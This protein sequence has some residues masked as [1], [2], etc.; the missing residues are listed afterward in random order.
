MDGED[1][2]QR[3]R[4]LGGERLGRDPDLPGEF[5]IV[6]VRFEQHL[7]FVRRER[8][9]RIVP[10]RG[11][12]RALRQRRQRRAEAAE[13]QDLDFAGEP[14]ALEGSTDHHLGDG[15]RTGIG[16][17]LAGEICDRRD[18][19]VRLGGPDQFADVVAR[20]RHR[21]EL[22]PGEAA[23]DRCRCGDLG[24]RQFAGEHVA[25][26]RSTTGAR[27]D[28]V[29][30]QSRLLEHALLE[31]HRPRQCRD[32]AAIL[33]DSDF[34]GEGGRRDGHPHEHEHCRQRDAKPHDPSLPVSGCVDRTVR[35][36]RLH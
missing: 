13:R 8:E 16:D 25:Q 10:G 11:G 2:A 21:L 26:R 1:L 32:Q 9:R 18:A 30:R 27:G 6:P 14:L 4:I 5:R 17:L 23:R 3:L 28:A 33:G 35:C 24:V 22:D 20:R 7:V 34:G 29:D 31:R 36:A 12:D 19:G 15:F